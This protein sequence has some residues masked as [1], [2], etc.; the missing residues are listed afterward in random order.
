[1]GV[2]RHAH[3]EELFGYSAHVIVKSLAE[4]D[5][6]RSRADHSSTAAAPELPSAVEKVKAIG[7]EAPGKYL[8]FFLDYDGTLAPIAAQPGDTCMPESIR[9]LLKQLASLCTVAIVSGRDRA[10]VEKTVGLPG[11]IYAGSHGFDISGPDGLHV[12]YPEANACLPDLY[13]AQKV[14]N[15]LL[16]DVEGVRLERKKYALAVHYPTV[17][18]DKVAYVKDV[19]RW[20]SHA[21]ERLTF[22]TGK[23]G[24]ELRPALDWHKGKAVGWIMDA[25]QLDL[26]KAVPIYLG[27]DITDEDAFRFLGDTGVGILVGGHGGPTKAA[28]RLQDMGEVEQ[29]LLIAVQF[30]KK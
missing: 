1:V 30:L 11:L 8:A 29:L 17:P 20:V 10:D 13:N 9:E 27:D 5:L 25:L 15:H 18:D 23:K 22:T 2:A 4:L 14:L 6:P 24:L 16:E 28:Y 21:S 3:A 7:S 19:V 12:Q 26:A